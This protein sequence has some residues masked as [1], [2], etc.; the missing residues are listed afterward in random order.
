MK[1]GLGLEALGDFFCQNSGDSGLWT[2][3]SPPERQFFMECPLKIAQNATLRCSSK[4]LQQC[5]KSSI[6]HLEM[7]TEETYTRGREAHVYYYIWHQFDL[8]DA[9]R[10]SSMSYLATIAC[11]Y[12]RD[13]EHTR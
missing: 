3:S 11:T 9:T 8:P 1:N 4:H 12:D 5:T 13:I 7:F 2:S 6:P 10:E